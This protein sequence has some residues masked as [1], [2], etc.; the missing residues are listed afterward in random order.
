MMGLAIASLCSLG[1]SGCSMCAAGSATISPASSDALAI[2]R[3]W[4]S[5][6]ITGYEVKVS[7]QD[8]LSDD[9]WPG[10]L[11]YCHRFYF[12]CPAGLI[13]PDEVHRDVGLVWVRENGTL[14][15]KKKSLFRKI[16]IPAEML[17]HLVISHMKSD[18][19]HPF[20]SDRREYLEALVL[21]KA[22]R[23]NLGR[24]VKGKF[25]EIIEDLKKENEELTER[26]ARAEREQGAFDAIDRIV[27]R[28][29]I[30]GWG[31][32]DKLKN[33]ERRLEQT[34]DPQ[35]MDKLKLLKRELCKVC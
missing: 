2:K 28:F 7:R 11:D 18:R 13:S 30:R 9:K 22:D 25:A 32:A 21:D 23:R 29:D 19:K 27:E 12:A 1:S 34:V 15:T 8:F 14:Y 35:L 26:L 33:I 20:F 24:Y 3:S 5:P 4:T 6:C 17:Y 10:Y 16:D 31:Y